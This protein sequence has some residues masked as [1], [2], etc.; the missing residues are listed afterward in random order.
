VGYLISAAKSVL[1]PALSRFRKAHPALKLLLHD[2]SPKEQIDALRAGEL[3]VALIGQ[4]GAM[5][6]NDF[7][8][9]KLCSLGVC[10]ALSDSDPL[11]ARKTI[12]IKDLKNHGFIGI[13]ENQMPG[14]NRWMTALCRSA[15][16]KPHFVTITDGI[17]HVLSQVVSESGV[18][19]LPSYFRTFT[20]PGVVFVPISDPGAR[21]DF[22][23]LWQRGKASA[24]TRALVKA[25][26]EAAQDFA[27]G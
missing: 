18:T 24:P 3:D 26:S 6:V 9:T 21:W 13:D 19:L 5:A 11:A 16:F 14:R 1:T 4:E 15:G 7:H 20:H 17:T 23:L 2:M 25:L 27:L 22:I 8:S 10:A 12:A